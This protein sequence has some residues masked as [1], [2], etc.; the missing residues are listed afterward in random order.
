M[1]RRAFLH[2]SAATLLL[3]ESRQLLRADADSEA[4]PPTLPA[5]TDALRGRGSLQAHAHRHGSLAGAAVVV[6]A[7]QNDPALQQLIAEQYGIV[8]PENELKWVALRPA[9]DQFDFKLSDALFDFAQAHHLKV[10]GHTMVWHNSVPDWLKSGAA[11]LD[12]RKLLIDHIHTVLGRYRGR[13][14]SWDVVNEAILPAD[15][16]P[17]NLRK[18]F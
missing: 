1:E 12:V 4:L 2:T 15:S 16:Q 13:V 7:L 10:R 8:V 5:E 14:H 6:R 11:K 9:Q 3:A 18:S 17:D